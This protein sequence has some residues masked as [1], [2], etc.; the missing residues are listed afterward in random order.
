MVDPDVRAVP[1]GF[2]HW[3]VYNIPAG[4]RFMVGNAPRGATEGITGFGVGRYNGPCPPRR[5]P[6]HHY[7]F[8]LY[9]LN[10]SQLMGHGLTRAGL[11]R[12]I[13]GHVVGMARLV[14][15]FQRP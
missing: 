12:A 8:T 1:H 11:L 9:A 5:D 10:V 15:K 7:V 6:P 3:V 2:V 14:G 4:W 13:G